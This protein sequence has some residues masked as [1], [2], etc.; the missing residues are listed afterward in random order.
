[1]T[2][3]DFKKH[4]A[5]IYDARN[6]Y[7]ATATYHFKYTHKL[8]VGISRLQSL[9]TALRVCSFSYERVRPGFQ[10]NKNIIRHMKS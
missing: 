2:D 7:T 3:D 4:E 5:K 1:M 10:L 9:T 6:Y 8:S